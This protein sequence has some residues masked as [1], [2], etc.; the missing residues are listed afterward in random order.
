[1]S[2]PGPLGNNPAPGNP[3]TPGNPQP[4]GGGQQPQNQ[5]SYFTEM[6]QSMFGG[7]DMS[8]MLQN[9]GLAGQTSLGAA[10]EQLGQQQLGQQYQNTLAGLGLSGQRLQLLRQLRE[11]LSETFRVTLLR[12]HNGQELGEGPVAGEQ[13][14]R[15]PRRQVPEHERPLGSVCP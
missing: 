3:N 15:R 4:N 11:D 12:S 1:M 8:T 9:L 14:L 10:N 13:L 7:I 2:V 6:L 5:Q